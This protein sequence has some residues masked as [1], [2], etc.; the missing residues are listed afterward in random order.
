[1]KRRDAFRLIP[2]AAAGVSALSK[3]VSAEESAPRPLDNGQPRPLPLEYPKVIMNMLDWVRKHQSANMME[4]A[5][6]ISRTLRKG[7]KVWINWDQGHSTQGEMFPGRHGM[8][9]FLNHGYDPGKAKDGDVLMASRILSE[10]GF[11]DVAKKNIVVIG[12][13]SPWSG[14]AIG[15]ENV[16]KDIW[17]LKI[18]AISDIWIETNITSIG[19]ILTA[20][21]MPAPIG[22]VSGP[23][24]LSIMWAILADVL[25]VCSVEG[26]KVSIMGDEP[27][28][29]GNSVNWIDTAFPLMDTY[30]D[31]VARELELV[32]SELGDIRKTATMIVDTLLGGGLVYYYSRYAAT[33]RGEATGRRGGFAFAKGISDGEDVKLTQKDCVI[34]GV[35]QPD[36]PV[37]LKNLDIFKK[38]GARVASVGPIMRDFTI[39]E[40]R[41]VHKETEVHTGRMS[42]TY[43]LFAVPNIDKHVCPTS[44]ISMIAVHW[45]TSIEVIEQIKERTGGNVPGVHFSGVLNWG[46]DFNRRIRAIAQDRGY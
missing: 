24:Y 8:P 37:D 21:G 4:A 7:G 33:Y 3:D 9:E 46:N 22:P 25:R 28:L 41:C 15:N 31:T 39:P 43:G 2:A 40:G 23:L 19:P 6:A 42:D 13:P 16:R 30:L 5:Y 14:D 26:V 35:F 44:G 1:M 36:D 10:Q 20:P 12:A 38:A 29:S 34:M 17:K 32:G 45:A 18:R 27:K 11:E